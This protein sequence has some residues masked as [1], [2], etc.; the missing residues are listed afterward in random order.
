MKKAPLKTFF[1]FKTG[2]KIIQTTDYNDAHTYVINMCYVCHQ[3]L[4]RF[5]IN[6]TLYLPIGTKAQIR[7]QMLVPDLH[8]YTLKLHSNFSL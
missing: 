6:R 7:E 5:F 1:A 4:I 2:V 8:V 3:S